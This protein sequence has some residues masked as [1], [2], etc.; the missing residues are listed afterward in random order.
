VIDISTPFEMPTSG[1]IIDALFGSGLSRAL[2]NEWSGLVDKINLTGLPVVSIDIPS[3]LF[4]DSISK[5]VAIDADYTL[6]LQTPKIACLQKENAQH[7]GHL[8]IIDIGLHQASIDEIVVEN[9]LVDAT[10]IRSILPVRGTF[11]HKGTYGHALLICG[12]FGKVGAALLAARA[13]LRVGA[14]KLTVHAPGAAY[15]ILQL[16]LPEAMV[17]VDGHDYWFTHC[18]NLNRY[19]AIGVGCGLGQHNSTAQ[20]V[21]GILEN[22]ASPLVVDADALNIIAQNEGWLEMIPKGSIITP[23]PGEYSRLFDKT[24]DSFAR[25]EQQ[26]ERSKSLGIYIVYKNA[27]TCIT[28]PEGQAFFNITGNPGMATAGSG[29]VLTGMITG[30]LAQKLSPQNA[31][32]AAVY[33]HGL[34]GDL[35]IQETGQYALIASDIINH[36][37]LAINKI[38]HGKPL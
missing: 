30:L 29:D 37:G 12:G 24:L 16:G 13:C 32:L 38:M 3:G 1:I 10:M 5:G 17:E 9:Y 20:G 2:E 35:A 25:I 4:G 27:R 19:D 8:V 15:Q 26:K 34:A 28:T 36:I 7:T 14:G 6:C 23:H 11:D 22:T 21:R 18:A 33:L 31:A